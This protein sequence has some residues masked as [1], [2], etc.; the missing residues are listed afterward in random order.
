MLK[1]IA[2][3]FS[4]LLLFFILLF[5]Y[6]KIAGFSLGRIINYTE[7]FQ[8]GPR[9]IYLPMAAGKAKDATESTSVEPGSNEIA[10]TVTLSYE[11]R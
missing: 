11:V 2:A 7:N 9:P 8:G 4:T 1:Q 5:A 6:T 10:L 3:A